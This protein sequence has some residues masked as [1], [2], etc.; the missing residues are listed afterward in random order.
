MQHLHAG[1][2]FR[3]RSMR[4]S[5]GQ[6]RTAKHTFDTLRSVCDHAFAFE[7]VSFGVLFVCAVKGKT[8]RQNDPVER[9]PAP[10]AKGMADELKVRA[11]GTR[12]CFCVCRV[13]ARVCL[14]FAALPQCSIARRCLS[15]V[16][17]LQAHSFAKKAAIMCEVA[18]NRTT[19]R[20]S[21]ALWVVPWTLRCR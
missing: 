11:L 12:Q 21:V 19:R 13:V 9:A 14:C 2:I 17:R 10:V 1:G 16:D 7:H 4:R 5:P 20:A 6:K 18:R 15:G 8:K 3:E